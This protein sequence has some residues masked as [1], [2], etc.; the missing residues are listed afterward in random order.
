MVINMLKAKKITALLCAALSCAFTLMLPVFGA[1]EC[2]L[3][4]KSKETEEETVLS[5]DIPPRR[6]NGEGSYDQRNPKRDEES[7]QP[8][9]CLNPR[10]PKEETAGESETIPTAAGATYSWYCPHQKNGAV[11][12]IPSEMSFIE[13]HG[14]YFLDHTAKEDD[15]V[16]YL[17]FDVGYANENVEKILDALK[18]ENVPGAFFILEHLITANTDLVKRMA[19]E[20]HLV[21][22]HTPRHRDMSLVTDKT[23]FGEELAKLEAIYKEATG[24]D[25]A[26]YYR[27]PEGRFNETNLIHAEELGYKTVFWSFA[28]ADWDNEK[29]MPSAR[30]LEKVLDGTHNGEVLLL[31]PTSTTNAEILPELIRRWKSMGYR[32]GTLDEL[33]SET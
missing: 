27:P 6:G 25:M 14:G 3:W 8:P 9:A 2:F 20:G 31:H 18:E 26:K 29:Q 28:Y 1:E 11:P 21:C 7:L 22:N 17:T 5:E 23:T 4:G 33:V 19:E 10:S 15:K 30:A 24:Y 12:I 13:D 32:F 16:I